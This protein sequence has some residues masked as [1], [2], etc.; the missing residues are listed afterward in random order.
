MQFLIILNISNFF[1]TF[2]LFFYFQSSISHSPFT[3]ILWNI[4]I[5][6][7][8]FFYKFFKILIIKFSNS[9]YFFYSQFL[10]ISTIHLFL[11]SYHSSIPITFLSSNS[12]HS[13]HSS[14]I[15]LQN[16]EIANSTGNSSNLRF[17]RSFKFISISR[18]LRIVHLGFPVKTNS[19]SRQEMKK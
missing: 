6:M 18:S 7:F 13:H 16:I 12:Y 15:K 10:I 14:L 17:P 5:Y 4:N 8:H 9:Y 19:A 2:L 11:N 1:L 3:I